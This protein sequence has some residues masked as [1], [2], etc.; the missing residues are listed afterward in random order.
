MLSTL[1]LA[2]GELSRLCISPRVGSQHWAHR[3]LPQPPPT[4]LFPPPSPSTPPLLLCFHQCWCQQ[5]C[6]RRCLCF[7]HYHHHH[8]HMSHSHP[9]HCFHIY[10]RHFLVDCCLIN[11][12][13]CSADATVNAAAAA[14]VAATAAT[15]PAPTTTTVFAPPTAAFY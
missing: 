9:K 14:P 1:S 5:F 10:H 7:C 12:C 3:P 4:P 13:H 11:H 15:V 6:H 2:Q 8:F